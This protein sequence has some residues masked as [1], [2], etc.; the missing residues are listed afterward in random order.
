MIRTLTLGSC[1]LALSVSV[2][3][4][5]A[6]AESQRIAVFADPA[7]PELTAGCADP[8]R[9]GRL[10]EGKGRELVFLTA[11]QLADAQQLT[12]DNIDLLVLPYGP[13]LPKAA[14]DSVRAFLRGGGDFLS[15]GGYAFD[16]LYGGK[17][18]PNVELLRAPGLEADGAAE[19]WR[20]D[21]ADPEAA[22]P[23][24]LGLRVVTA[25]PHSGKRCIR[26]HVPDGL[27]HVWYNVH[28]GVEGLVPG[29]SYAASCWIRTERVH[30]GF[31]YLAVGFYDADGK[32]LSFA[33]NTG[34]TNFCGTRD[35]QRLECRFEV[36]PGTVVAQVTGNLYGYGTAFF[37]DF[38]LKWIDVGG[39]NT[40]FG[41]TGDQLRFRQDQIGVF[42]P[43]YRL[44]RAVSSH[45]AAHQAIVTAPCAYQGTLAGYAAVGMTSAN[46]AVGPIPR[47]RWTSL[48]QTRDRYG[49]RTGSLLG[50]THNFS[51][52]FRHSLWAYTGVEN[53]DL[54]DGAQPTFEQALRQV[55]DHM[56]T[57]VFLHTPAA[58]FML[59][60]PG[61][62]MKGRVNLCN[63]GRLERELCVVAR[64]VSGDTVVAESARA[65][66][67]EPGQD[68]R[69]E[70]G[71]PCPPAS[72]DVVCELRY[73][74]QL[75]GRVID[76]V[77]A[78]VFVPNG[79]ETDGFPLSFQDNYFRA[80]QRPMMLFGV[81]QTGV[82][83]GPHYENPL[84]W[85][86]D[87]G[88]CRDFG[89]NVWRVLHVSCFADPAGYR[90][91]TF[92]IG[93]PPERLLRRM[94]AAFQ[95]AQHYGIVPMPCW[96]DTRGGAAV[97]DE[98][99]ALQA[100]F[101]R[102]YGERYQ[103]LSGMLY[104]VSNEVTIDY[105]DVPDLQRDFRAFLTERY[106]TDDAL[107]A[108][109]A[110]PEASLTTAKYEKPK[111]EWHSRR[112][113]DIELFRVQVMERWLAASIEAVRDTGDRHPVTTENYVYK[114]PGGDPFESRRHLT[115]ANMH[116]YGDWQPGYVRFFARRMQGMGHVVGEFGRT[117]HPAQVSFRNYTPESA[118]L[119]YFR[120]VT[121]LNAGLGATGLFVWD[122]KDLRGSAFPYGIHYHSE[123]VPK[124]VGHQFRNLAFFFRRFTS[125][126][127]PEKLWFVVP[128]QLL[129]GARQNDLQRY[130]YAALTALT[131]TNVPF[132]TIRQYELHKI[133]EHKPEAV[134][135]PLSYILSDG[136]V[137]TLLMYAKGGG[138]VYLSG[139]CAFDPDRQETRRHV[140]ERLVGISPASRRF[141]DIRLGSVPAVH[142]EGLGDLPAFDA[143]PTYEFSGQGVDVLRKAADLP[144][145]CSRKAGQGE[146]VFVNDPIELHLDEDGL[147][148]I[149]AD[150]AARIGLAPL[151]PA[152][153]DSNLIALQVP[154][155]SGG[156]LT[157]VLN[158]GAQDRNVEVGDVRALCPAGAQVAVYRSASGQIAALALAGDATLA[159][160]PFRTGNGHVLL[161]ALDGGDLRT[162][163]AILALPLSQGN[164]GLTGVTSVMQARIGEIVNGRWVTY[165]QIAD[166]R[167]LAIDEQRTTAMVLLTRDEADGTWTRRVEKMVLSPE[168]MPGL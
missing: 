132:S 7:V 81:N 165:E 10:L 14:C 18:N 62:V 61:E 24:A 17:V 11:E 102:R 41:R 38:S 16:N 5:A 32:R 115:F 73:E 35:W 70:F 82:M 8:R 76:T 36:P 150:F 23:E 122:I 28:Q 116:H 54:L 151:L 99:L 145:I 78:G 67:L 160:A 55:A 77:R 139:D 53:V 143:Y 71:L 153:R 51:G 140:L 84:T 142:A 164:L 124:K 152:S 158:D 144:L 50:I 108:A 31:T 110:N 3:R 109:W 68:Q 157:V 121:F 30:G 58:E 90:F 125:T 34:G 2:L 22:D 79:R 48:V 156:S 63:A 133:L 129:L 69:L 39:M 4:P 37:D 114:L 33:Q 86:E 112:D 87:Y 163:Q 92:N 42:D 105:A 93:N 137:D 9:L 15:V 88:R 119:S 130:L 95:L 40:H 80:G 27:P 59:Y 126:F 66:F 107:R 148:P 113:R 166:G 167:S 91:G 89:F 25:N 56:L 52:T 100:S 146:V 85:E 12:A 94:D 131:R 111:G 43:S 1:V 72:N 135:L 141:P 138:T 136:D 134:M 117:T 44:E 13:S 128:D 123:L 154:S 75:E 57:G 6:A 159:G 155:E 98:H 168:S 103:D 65:V 64:A 47:A 49:R 147:L 20:S 60:R 97:S 45:I 161:T 21:Q 127:S 106:G 162:S 96:Y 149:Y 29:E 118:A 104:D 74:L 46:D 83:F 120:R 101:A 19:C 26:L